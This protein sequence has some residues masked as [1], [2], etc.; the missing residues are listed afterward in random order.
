MARL[1]RTPD[2]RRKAAA[3]SFRAG[4]GTIDA[5]VLFSASIGGCAKAL[6]RFGDAGGRGIHILKRQA[7]RMIPI[8][9]TRGANSFQF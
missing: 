9:A 2:A 7:A 8:G 3:N 6:K 1:G 4:G 5:V